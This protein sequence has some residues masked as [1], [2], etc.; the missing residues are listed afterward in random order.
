M[1]GGQDIWV[2]TFLHCMNPESQGMLLG[3]QIIN[4]MSVR[5][6]KEN[7]PIYSSLVVFPKFIGYSH[8]S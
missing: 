8:D 1:M 6:L 2:S 5:F 7:K 3:I 4:F